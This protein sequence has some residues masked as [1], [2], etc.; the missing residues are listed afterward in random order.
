VGT[1][2]RIAAA[3]GTSLDELLGVSPA[4]RDLGAC[5][6]SASGRCLLDV[7]RAPGTGKIDESS[8]LTLR[9]LRLL[10]QFAALLQSSEQDVL[11]ALDVL[12]T[13]LSAAAA[14]RRG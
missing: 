7:V 12:L 9:Q 14:S 8:V 13:K 11:S 5:P 1:A 3:L 6:V 2:L 10:R 4:E